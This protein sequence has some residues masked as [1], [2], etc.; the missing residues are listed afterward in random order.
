MKKQKRYLFYDRLYFYP[1]VVSLVLFI[2]GTLTLVVLH[3]R[4]LTE[5]TLSFKS[6]MTHLAKIAASF[7]DVDA[8]NRIRTPQ[9]YLSEQYN[10][11]LALW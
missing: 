6:S 4:F 5:S 9:Q 3:Q 7:I 11:T 2:S 10:K 8:H 1:V